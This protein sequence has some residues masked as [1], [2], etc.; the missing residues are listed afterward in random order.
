MKKWIKPPGN[1]IL[2]RLLFPMILVMLVQM[3]LPFGTILF[4]GTIGQLNQNAFELVN[5]RVSNRK[6]YLEDDM[7]QRW[8]EITGS[9]QALE[10][11]ADAFLSQ[12]GITAAQL[13]RGSEDADELLYQA[14]SELIYLL[15]KNEVTGVYYILAGEG[16]TADNGTIYKNGLFIRNAD[17]A[18]RAADNSDL[19]I[20]RAPVSVA[21]RLGIPM[22]VGWQRWF[23]FRPDGT[24]DGYDSFYKPFRAA[25]AARRTDYREFG[26]WSSAYRLEEENLDKI[27]YSIPLCLSDG[28]PY[29]VLGVSITLDYLAKQLPYDELFSDK[30]GSYLLGIQ[31][32][33]LQLSCLVGTGPTFTRFFGQTQEVALEK[34]PSYQGGY[35]LIGASQKNEKIFGCLQ[36]LHLYD[37]NSRFETER[38]VLIGLVPEKELMSFS[39]RIQTNVLISMSVSLVFGLIAVCITGGWLARPV[40]GLARQ[41]KNSNPSQP[42]DLERTRISEL[43][44]LAASIERLSRDVA[45]SAS[46]LSKI[47]DTAGVM[48]GAFEFR[49]KDGQG[50]VFYTQSF[51][52]MTGL[53]PDGSA[54]GFGYME[55]DKFR[56][57]VEPL[58][59]YQESSDEKNGIFVFRIPVADGGYRWIRIKRVEEEDSYLGVAVDVTAD[60][61]AKQ[62]VEYERDNDPLT[63]LIT[64]RGFRTRLAELF[65]RPERLG[66]GALIMM[67]LDNMKYVNDTYGHDYGDEY[68][69][70]AADVLK[71][72][73]PFGAV[74][75][76]MSGDEFYMFLYGYKDQE[77]VR[78][79]L[80]E[81][82][83]EIKNTYLT[84]IDSE[85][86][87]LRASIGY[88]WY[89]ADSQSYE[90]LIRFADFAM[91]TVK[92]TTKGDFKAFD[93]ET[94]KKE[95]YLLHNREDLNTL[96]DEELVEYHFQPVVDA[97]TGEIFG[98][99][100]LMRSTMETLR[101]PEEILAIARSQS[102]LADIERLTWFHALQSFTSHFKAPG[103][104]KL[105][106]NS[107]P[108]QRLSD[109]DVEKLEQQYGGYLS[110]VVVELTE[111]EKLNQEFTD[112][113]KTLVKRWQADMALDDFGTGYNGDVVLLELTPNFVKISN[114]LIRGVDRDEGRQK[115]L[116]NLLSYASKRQIQSIAEG[117]ET[118]EELRYLIRAGVDYVQGNWLSRP[119]AAPALFVSEE[120][121]G[122][123]RDAQ[124]R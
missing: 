56:E 87:K 69:R 33:D 70:C 82:Q 51:L 110:Q 20:E 38:W 14:S 15:R 18:T 5:E 118:E 77:A 49:R 84:S 96:I 71:K 114:E 94:Y 123:I 35:R 58:I 54:Q 74:A 63:G 73:I 25:Q 116:Q 32:Q 4:G 85:V 91:Y 9:A 68:I 1:S 95:A 21:R 23:A 59:Q 115:I 119:S 83:R 81:L 80:D 43:D 47:L 48:V 39:N 26:Y 28:T 42:V 109:E 19:I 29:A 78:Q 11:A 122:I 120:I 6:Y 79:L 66:V 64:R 98:Y 36:E 103:P 61:E 41:V 108:N 92:H 113:K 52:S 3:M 34:Q 93:M 55:L 53:A 24:G 106:I 111:E 65:S 31:G 112:W 62:R 107:I 37:R 101:S 100:A 10:A 27:S 40:A 13:S 99:E 117:V 44:E 17:P 57:K 8:S 12:R 46:K 2:R 124:K 45:E 105:F 88:A 60:V 72:F 97:R 30:K 75:A 50:K 76:H 102:K 121:V 86:I 90:E 22:D 16:E 67:D 7:V 104:R 89:P